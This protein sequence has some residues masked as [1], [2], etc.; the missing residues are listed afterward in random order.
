MCVNIL[1]FAD[2]TVLFFKGDNWTLVEKNAN[3]GLSLVNEW[4]R[5]VVNIA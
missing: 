4:Y 1:V 3:Y 2:D 5:R